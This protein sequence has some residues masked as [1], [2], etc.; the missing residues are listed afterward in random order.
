MEAFFKSLV[1]NEKNIY[2]AA[3]R[4]DDASVHGLRT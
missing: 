4:G 1:R 2:T 3:F